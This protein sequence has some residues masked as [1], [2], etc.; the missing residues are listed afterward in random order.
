MRIK[1][2][3]YGKLIPTYFQLFYDKCLNISVVPSKSGIQKSL[4]DEKMLIALL[5]INS[6]SDS[7]SVL[8]LL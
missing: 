3:R 7:F 6:D 2:H 8:V 1:F 5:L 4:L